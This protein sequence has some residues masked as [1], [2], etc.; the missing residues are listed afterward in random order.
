MKQPTEAELQKAYMATD[1]RFEAMM[2]AKA[3]STLGVF[4]N[5]CLALYRFLYED[6]FPN[7]LRFAARKD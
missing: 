1:E 6:D 7:N 2:A 4:K 5:P 3:S